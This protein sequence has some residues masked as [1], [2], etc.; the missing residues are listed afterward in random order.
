MKFTYPTPSEIERLNI[1]HR[2]I[3]EEEL[4]RHKRKVESLEV[5]LQI[6]EEIKREEAYLED[7]PEEYR[8]ILK[9]LLEEHTINA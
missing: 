2:D 5:L 1:I 3:S 6:V 9:T 8:P 4:K 7:Y